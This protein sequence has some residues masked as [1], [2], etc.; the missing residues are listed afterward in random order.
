MAYS[1]RPDEQDNPVCPVCGEEL[2]MG[3]RLYFNGN[4]GTIDG[5]SHRGPGYMFDGDALDYVVNV[6]MAQK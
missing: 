3:D 6:L 1:K 2:S 4:M 5:C